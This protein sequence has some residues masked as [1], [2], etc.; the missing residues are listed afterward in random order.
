M[1]ST[2]AEQLNAGQPSTSVEIYD[3]LG[4]RHTLY[5]A[6]NQVDRGEPYWL[7]RLF[8]DRKEIGGTPGEAFDIVQFLFRLTND[9]SSTDVDRH[10][11]GNSEFVWANGASSARFTWQYSLSQSAEEASIV[12]TQDGS[13]RS[14][15]AARLFGL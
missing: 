12:V 1:N 11:I 3:S 4:A 9:G 15:Y 5:V 14:L 13:P 10:S 2:V 6:F 8:I 7:L